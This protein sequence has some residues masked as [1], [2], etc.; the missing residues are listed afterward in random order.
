MRCGHPPISISSPPGGEGRSF[1]L[2]GGVPCAAWPN[3]LGALPHA[4][5]CADGL[6]SNL[7]TYHMYR[8]RFPDKVAVRGYAGLL[9]GREMGRGCSAVA[10]VS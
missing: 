9:M 7:C 4:A 10:S 1:A 8:E 6:V 2:G 5:K 3:R